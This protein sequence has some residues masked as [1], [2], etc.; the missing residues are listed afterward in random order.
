MTLAQTLREVRE[1]RGLSQVE[2]AEK[3][4]LKQATISD[5][6][7]GDTLRPQFETISKLAKALNVPLETFISELSE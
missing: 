2:L 7:R 3:S 1:G 4:G 6:E 5:L